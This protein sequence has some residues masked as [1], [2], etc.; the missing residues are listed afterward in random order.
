MAFCDHK[1]KLPDNVK[2][3]GWVSQ[4]SKWHELDGDLLVGKDVCE[5]RV[6]DYTHTEIDN[7]LEYHQIAVLAAKNYLQG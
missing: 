5:E 3:V 1:I 4:E 7:S 2:V 6:L